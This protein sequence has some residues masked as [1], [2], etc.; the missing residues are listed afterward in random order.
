MM[1]L[2]MLNRVSPM[3]YCDI[4]TRKERRL[5]KVYTIM[6]M[7]NASA[8]NMAAM[9][10]RRFMKIIGQSSKDAEKLFP[11]LLGKSIIL[12][13]PF[14]FKTVMSV[15]KP[16]MSK[17][18]VEKMVF[19]N[20][21]SSGQPITECPFLSSFLDVADVPTFLGGKC[22]CSGG[23]IPGTPNSQTTPINSISSD[24]KISI[25]VAARSSQTVALP[26]AKDC[27]ISVEIEVDT[28]KVEV[29]VCV[30]P[31][32]METGGKYVALME[33][34]YVS[35]EDGLFTGKFVTPISGTLIVN[36]DNTHSLM[37]SKTLKY[38]ID[39]T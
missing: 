15:V 6:D 37:R 3:H 2:M 26:V 11:Q 23:C 8:M 13:M 5:F 31:E 20:G 7:T 12:N 17:R 24:G 16:L 19:C 10:D 22:N 30:R 25:T 29:S 18:A 21:G 27:P 35:D 9:A 39:F 14:F 38:R 34:R 32:D 28:R 1:D 33:T 36:F 4:M